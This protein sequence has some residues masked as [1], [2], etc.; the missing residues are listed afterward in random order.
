MKNDNHAPQLSTDSLFYIFIAVALI[1]ALLSSYFLI[2]ERIRQT[3]TGFQVKSSLVQAENAASAIGNYLDDRIQYLKDLARQP[4]LANAV[5]DTLDSRENLEDYL[6]SLLILGRKE[7]VYLLN[8]LG[9]TIHQAN[10]LASSPTGDKSLF[11]NLEQ[12]TWFQDLINGNKQWV[13]QKY[14]NDKQAYFSIAVPVKYNG[15]SEGV[16]LV[17]FSNEIRALFTTTG[18]ASGIRIKGDY[19]QYSSLK[20]NIDYQK[21]DSR[22]AGLSEL[23][24]EYF[25]ESEQ[26]LSEVNQVVERVYIGIFASLLLAFFFLFLLGKKYFIDPF[27]VIEQSEKNL[28]AEQARNRELLKALDVS[29]VGVTVADCSQKDLP[30]IYANKA[31]LKITGYSAEEVVGHNHRFLVGEG[32]DPQTRAELSEALKAQKHINVEILNYTKD[33]KPFW[34]DVSISPVFDEQHNLTAFV[35]VQNDIT[36]KIHREQKLAETARQLELVVDST[37]VGIWDWQIQSG[38]VSFNER[39]AEITGHTLEELEPISIDTWMQ[40][41]HPDD[42]EQSGKLLKKHWDGEAE[43]YECEARMKHKQGH[44]VWVLDTG[45]VVEWTEDGQPARMIGTHLDITERKQTEQQLREAKDIAEQASS[46]K[47]EFLANMSH[48]IRTPMNGVIGMTN[49][50]LDTQLNK[51]QHEYTKTVKS[52]AESLLHI[53][54]DIL[55]FSKVEAG[56]L[57]LEHIDFDIGLLLDQVGSSLAFRIQEKQL[58]LICPANP[59]LHQWFHADPGRIR[60]IL[61]NLIGNACKFTEQGEVAVYYEIHEQ[62]DTHSKVCIK[63]RDTGIGLSKAQKERLFERFSQAD[64]STTRKYGGT[65]LGLAISQQLVEIMGGEI[66]VESEPGKGSTFWFT[67]TL[68]HASQQQA[69]EPMADLRDQKILAIDDN[70]TSLQLLDELLTNWKVNHSTTD[71]GKKGLALMQQA[72]TANQPF[73]IIIVDQNMPG[74]DAAAFATEV[75]NDP[76]LS[77]SRLVVLASNG[78]RGDARK[79]KSMGYSGYISKPIEQ[80]ILYN[81]LLE[82]SEIMP[83]SANMYSRENIR[84]LPQFNAKVLVVEDNATNQAVARGMLEKFGITIDLAGNGEEALHALEMIDYDL[85]FMDCQMPVMDGY[86]ASRRIRDHLQLDLLPIVAMTANAMEGD[87]EKCLQA[88]MNDHIPKPVDPD[89]LKQALDTWLS[90]AHKLNTT[91]SRKAL[92]PATEADNASQPA[93]A[94]LQTDAASHWDRE[95]FLTR[96][97]GDEELAE[98]IL[99]IFLDDM[100][101]KLQS[102]KKQLEAGNAVTAGEVAHAI[103]GSCANVGAEALRAQAKAMEQAGKAGDLEGVSS[104]MNHLENLFSELLQLIEHNKS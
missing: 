93:P 24:I 62:S 83:D 77:Q 47:S 43:R 60:Q 101:D 4:L 38:Q 46:A 82:V 18:S 75:K 15:G 102:L 48:E 87:R 2:G 96:L 80:S 26:L 55:D 8:I 51:Q 39:W 33:N 89:R 67:L 85:V 14:E 98:T 37:A 3:T 97:A 78:K 88:G 90:E 65:G 57:E 103:K 11:N 66:G 35:G 23:T 10:H 50:L 6:N 5:M 28:R 22:N 81:L 12:A 9:E 84:Q 49:L 32:T 13:I 52:S 45:K 99:Q 25:N 34:N 36:D 104:R 53:I 16:L 20:D 76:A 19:L 31:F 95:G 30:V 7:P 41:A 70:A 92:E 71:S 56:K 91:D 59:V 79:C 29:P 54:N 74:M 21:V 72:L 61:T 69:F 68:P 86:E 94:A 42:L 1:I 27:K 100:P 17:R 64:G 63:V 73:N 44:W 40:L 58:E